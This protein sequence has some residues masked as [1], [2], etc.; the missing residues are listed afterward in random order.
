MVE[1]TDF[2]DQPQRMIQRQQ[3][4]QRP[5]TDALGVLDGRRQEDTRRRRH[6]Q[7]CG[8][9]FGQVIA[10][11][12]GFVSHLEESH[13]PLI[14]LAQRVRPALQVIKYAKR[15]ITH[16]VDLLGP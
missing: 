14:Q 4:H 6:A 5:Q 2:T 12:T 13:A 3:I 11:K 9:V 16:T 15:N 1:H 7:R 10:V 8:M